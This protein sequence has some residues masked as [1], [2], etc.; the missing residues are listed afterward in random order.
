ME[1]VRARALAE[2]AVPRVV[3]VGQARPNEG[4]GVGLQIHHHSLS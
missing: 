1:K 4:R 2:R 3:I